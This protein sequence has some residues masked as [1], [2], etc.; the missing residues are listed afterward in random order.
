MNK[1]ERRRHI[2]GLASSAEQGQ[3]AHDGK[4]E[5]LMISI[6]KRRTKGAAYAEGKVKH[7]L[8]KHE[9][10]QRGES[11]TA[12]QFVAQ[13]SIAASRYRNR[14][15]P[16]DQSTRVTLASRRRKQTELPLERASR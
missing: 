13:L 12:P 3:I 15:Q 14:W 5:E 16:A 1:G 6:M 9:V 11:Q 2:P 8:K 4:A 10:S 7:F